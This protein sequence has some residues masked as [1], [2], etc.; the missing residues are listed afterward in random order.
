[1]NEKLINNVTRLIALK[2]KLNQ[3]RQHLDD[4]EA[5]MYVSSHLHSISHLPPYRKMTN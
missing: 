1:M 5:H 3:Q 2:A 4:L